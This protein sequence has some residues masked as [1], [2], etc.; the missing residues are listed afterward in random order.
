MPP[1]WHRRLKVTQGKLTQ[2]VI[3]GGNGV[4]RIHAA[5]EGEA[6]CGCVIMWTIKSYLAVLPNAFM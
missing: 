4:Q 2:A 6:L 1:V 5:L 3:T